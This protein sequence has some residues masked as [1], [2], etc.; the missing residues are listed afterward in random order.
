MTVK[1]MQRVEQR[2]GE[3]RTQALALR[4]IVADEEAETAG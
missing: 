4:E 2:A 3:D 1:E